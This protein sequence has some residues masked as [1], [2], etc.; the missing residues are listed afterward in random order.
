MDYRLLL[1]Y[2]MT[3]QDFLDY[4]QEVG[5]ADIAAPNP[6]AP[7]EELARWVHAFA[8]PESELKSVVLWVQAPHWAYPV[9]FFVCGIESAGA[10]Q[11]HNESALPPDL[12][13]SRG[14]VLE[15]LTSEDLTLAEAAVGEFVALMQGA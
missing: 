14:E 4:A 15:A 10:L 9:G 7:R 6:E 5:A 2:T 12:Y 11:L 8:I 13:L 1:P 3:I